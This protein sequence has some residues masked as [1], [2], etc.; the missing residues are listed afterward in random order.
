MMNYNQQCEFMELLQACLSKA[1]IVHFRSGLMENSIILRANIGPHCADPNCNE[2]L[3][4]SL[5]LGSEPSSS[6]ASPHCSLSGLI[7]GMI[8]S[9]RLYEGDT[10]DWQSL[11]SLNLSFA[12]SQESL[13]NEDAYGLIDQI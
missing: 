10:M 6:I 3:T 7:T 11:N 1:D 13:P 12:H 8:E 9:L 5:F 2:H 4:L